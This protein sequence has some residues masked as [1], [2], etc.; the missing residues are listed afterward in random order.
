MKPTPGELLAYYYW[1]A[2][3]QKADANSTF[4]SMNEQDFRMILAVLGKDH[5][6]VMRIGEGVGDRALRIEGMDPEW[7]HHH[8]VER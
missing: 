8:S 6:E 2:Q 5:E 3:E 4:I 1:R 7:V